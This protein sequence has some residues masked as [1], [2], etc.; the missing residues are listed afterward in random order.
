MIEKNNQSPVIS[1]IVTHDYQFIKS[2]AEET[3]VE[4]VDEVL[5]SHGQEM[6]VLVVAVCYNE[7]KMIP[8][9]LRHY[10]KIAE[11]ILVFD[12]G[13]T[14]KSLELL[15][16]NPKVSIVSVPNSKMNN[17]ELMKIRNEGWKPYRHDYD[18]VIVCD[19][20]EFLWHK[21]LKGKLEE[22][23]KARITVPAVTGYQMTAEA[24]PDNNPLTQ[25]YDHFNEGYP[26]PEH[27]NKS[28]IF[29]P[30]CVDIRYEM[31]CHKANP[32]GVV[33]YS[34]ESLYLFHYKYVGY[35]EFI[36]RN[37]MLAARVSDEDKKNNWAF[38]YARDAQMSFKDFREIVQK[39]AP[40]I[41][42]SPVINPLLSRK[43]LKAQNAGVFRE[44]IE[45]NEYRV[46]KKDFTNK[47]VIDVGANIGV[48]TLL[49]NEYGAERIVAVE[50]NTP[51][52]EVLKKNTAGRG[53]MVL[54]K[55]AGKKGGEHVQMVMRP[56]FCATDGRI[57]SQSAPTGIETIGLDHLVSLVDDGKPILLKVDCEGAEYD[58]FYGASLKALSKIQTIVMEAHENIYRTEGQ[59]GLIDKLRH[60]LTSLGFEEKYFYSVGEQVKMIRFDRVNPIEDNITVVI[61]AFN[62]P[63][64]L[65]DQVEAIRKQTLQPKEIIVWLTK[66][67]HYENEKWVETKFE[68]PEGVTLVSTEKDLTLPARFAA[69]LF[70]KTNYVLLL[71]D[72]VFPAE[73]YLEETL[74]VSKRENAVVS[75]YGML[76]NRRGLNDGEADRYGDHGTKTNDPIEVDV[77]GHSW[78]GKKEWFSLFFREP[79]LSPTE[80]DDLHFSYI[81]KKYTDIRTI[82]SAMPEDNKFIWSN[83]NSDAG[84]GFRAL[85]ARKWDDVKIWTD[86]TKTSWG[87][88]DKDYLEKNLKAFQARRQ[89]M[90]N[91]YRAEKK[92]EPLQAQK[93]VEEQKIEVTVD[94]ATKN[95][96]FSTLPTTLLSVMMQTYPIKKIIIVDDSDP[97]KDGKMKD[98]RQNPMYQYLFSMISKKGIEWEVVFGVHKGQHHSHQIVMDRA[99]TDF[100][101]RLDDD[102]YA[103]PNV[104]EELVSQ[105]N[106][107]VGLVAGLVLD[108]IQSQQAP[109]NYFNNNR[110]ADINTRENTQW[111]M[112]PK[113]KTIEVEHLYSSFLYRKVEDIK[114]CLELSPAAH[115]EETLFSY[116]YVRKGWKALV[117]TSAVTWHFRNPE[118]GIRSHNNPDFW[119]GDDKIF[120]RKLTSWSVNTEGKKM[121]IIDAGIG[122]TIV[123]MQIVPELLKK[124]PNLVIGTYYFSLFKN[125]AVELVPTWTAKDIMG[126]KLAETQNVYRYLWQE[127]DKGRK[128][129]IL[130][131]YKEMFIEEKA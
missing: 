116:E 1:G 64:L 67:K 11:K 51:T 103:E 30:N 99:K 49:A 91:R 79:A 75:A 128:L 19:I 104:L 24:F 69:T 82:V 84:M 88:E 22:F 38:H 77:G 60:Y 18:W 9:F 47:N 44:I 3:K 39:G 96:Y 66:S 86:P 59:T 112:Q 4:W 118:G 37:K 113:G 90:M 46:S 28:M 6:N 54:D 26:D 20:D 31:G 101:W 41:N 14:D 124:W 92:W 131:A 40:I 73:G 105:M 129:H 98:L 114:Y 81:L 65:K 117:T 122:D 123:F 23:R 27:L 94:I 25:I 62:R 33:S 72:D 5:G 111:L 97:E 63:E 12:G 68:I 10:E 120:Q 45:L 29:N 127:S 125:Y 15:K 78:F 121:I 53:I 126:E 100:I 85:H 109:P 87:V 83:T 130:D 17:L 13:S 108:P 115:R 2:C 119:S 76:Y 102:E 42:D 89:Q 71:D 95:R 56:E 110:L 52:L 57:F 106:S 61:S 107:G 55:A 36:G 48:F 93:V 21:D 8:F 16:A 32:I 74:K 43:D 34:S 50:P 80:G 7:E 58:L 35:E 70:A